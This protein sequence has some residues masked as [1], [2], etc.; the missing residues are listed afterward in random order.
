M[1][2]TTSPRSLDHVCW[3]LL[4]F[5]FLAKRS[6]SCV[7]PTQVS[8]ID[9]SSEQDKLKHSG[10][11]HP[12][13]EGERC[14]TRECYWVSGSSYNAIRGG[15]GKAWTII[16][17]KTCSTNFPFCRSIWEF[18]FNFQSLIG[19]LSSFSLWRIF[20]IITQGVPSICIPTIL[21]TRYKKT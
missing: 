13:Y 12:E 14:Q 8:C 5:T 17:S 1:K 6:W 20:W 3:F 4:K 19:T 16:P 11:C 21:R 18:K 2:Y 7:N 9:G 10:Q 15:E